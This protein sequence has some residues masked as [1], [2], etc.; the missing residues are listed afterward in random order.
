MNAPIL[1]IHRGITVVRDDLFPGGTKARFIGQV[2]D[3]VAEAVYASPPEGGAQTALATVARA[4][5]KRATIFV[6]QR[7]KPHARTL[8]AARLGAKVVPVAPGYLTV[9]QA[10]AKAYCRETGAHLI[11]F[12]ADFPG[13]AEA[14]AS[15]ALMSGA[16]PDEVWCAAGSGVLARGLALAWPT[17][18]RHVVQIGR[19]L[20]PKD[21]AGA[22]INIH[23]RK[24]AEKAMIAAP[25]PADPHYDA[26]AWETCLIKHG[27]GRVLFWNVAPLPRP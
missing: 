5:G 11:P 2:F 3:G 6:A 24:F 1:E 9:V 18:R 17:A 19:E 10:R 15:S 7:A 16:A 13:A 21:V 20:V 4:L 12:G 26:K 22:T 8:E 25:F 14:I 23:P 27:S